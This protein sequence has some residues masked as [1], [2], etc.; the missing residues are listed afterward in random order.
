MRLDLYEEVMIL[1]QREEKTILLVRH[2]ISK[3]LYVLKKLMMPVD[4]SRYEQLRLHPHPHMANIIE[5][6]VREQI[7]YVVEE[8]VNGVSLEYAC[9]EKAMSETQK[10]AIVTELLEVLAHLHHLQPPL[11]HRDI[12]PSNIMLEN[13]HVKLI[14]FEIA[15]HVVPDQKKDTVMMGSVG[16]AAPEQYGFAQSDQRSDIYAV[17]VLIRELFANEKTNKRYRALIER[18]MQMDPDSRYANVEELRAAFVHCDGALFHFS[19]LRDWMNYVNLPFFQKERRPQSI[20]L[21]CYTI[22]CIIIA[23]SANYE[24]TEVSLLSLGILRLVMFIVLWLMMGIAMNVFHLL[25]LTSLHRSA[26]PLIR[27]FNGCVI[28]TCISITLLLM[29]SLVTTV[30]D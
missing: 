27:F 6:M 25:E 16:Y 2:A 18:C 17:G 9:S 10:K 12:K 29:A 1:Q 5:V 7:C 21:L 23:S 4:I 13:N 14:D 26:H 8:Y 19:A 22:F 28:W 20:L 15:R 11:I 3:Q 30:I 24:K